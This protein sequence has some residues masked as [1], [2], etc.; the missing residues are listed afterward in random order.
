MSIRRLIPLAA[1]IAVLW[2]LDT[3]L[4]RAADLYFLAVT[5]A[6]IALRE[7]FPFSHFPMYSRIS[8]RSRYLL[9]TD[10][11]DNLYPLRDVFGLS[12]DFVKRFYRSCLEDHSRTIGASDASKRAAFDTLQ[13]LASQPTLADVRGIRLYEVEMS[14]LER[15]IRRRTVLLAELPG[16]VAR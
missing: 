1:A 13:L 3:T 12:A 10:S 9:V 14:L 7:E 16:R 6:C 4:G 5:V 2:A 11:E 8:P 15:R